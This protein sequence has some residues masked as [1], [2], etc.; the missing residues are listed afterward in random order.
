MTA[1]ERFDGVRTFL[2]QRP[3]VGPGAA[4]KAVAEDASALVRAEIALAK[5]ELQ[6]ALAK[7]AAGAGMLVGAAVAGWLGLQGVLITVGFVLS[8][9][10]LPGWAA[11]AIV[12]GALLLVTALLALL[13]KRRMEAKVSLETTKQSVER[14]VAL[15]KSRLPGR[16]RRAAS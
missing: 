11:A 12:S 1:G 8:A 2:H 9:V 4:A 5:A 7:K 13:G 6:S 3:T 10:G 14:D 16:G 15:T